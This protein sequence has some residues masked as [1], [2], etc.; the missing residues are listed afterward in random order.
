MAVDALAVDL[1][2]RVGE[3]LGDILVG[4]PVDRNAKVIA[5]LFLEAGFDVG[6]GEP[7]VAEPIEVRELLVGELIELPVSERRKGKSDE[8]VEI[9]IRVG[10]FLAF[11]SHEISQ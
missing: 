3:I 1:F 9:E 8:I 5:E 10:D 11:A 6:P 4:R 2:H 7:V